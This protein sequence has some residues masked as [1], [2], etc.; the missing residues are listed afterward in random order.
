MILGA[1]VSCLDLGY[2]A[3]IAIILQSAFQKKPNLF[4]LHPA[5]NM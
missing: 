3:S 2:R 5:L 4:T 1:C